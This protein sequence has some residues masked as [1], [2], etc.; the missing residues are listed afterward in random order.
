MRRV[1]LLGALAAAL[2]PA[3]LPA[4]AGASHRAQLSAT[5]TGTAAPGANGT[6]DLTITNNGPDAI[7]FDRG[8]APKALDQVSQDGQACQVDGAQWHCGPFSAPANGEVHLVLHSP[9]GLSPADGPFQMFVSTDGKTDTGPF[10]IQWANAQ[11]KPCKCRKL[12]VSASGVGSGQ[13]THPNG[14]VSIGMTITWRLTC[15]AGKG[16]CRG[17]I[18]AVPPAGSDVQIAQPAGP[19]TCTAPCGKSTTGKFRLKARSVADLDFDNRAGKSFA[20]G[21][22]ITC[23]KRTSV[24][25][26]TLAFGPRGFLDRKQS[27]LNANGIPDG[28][29]K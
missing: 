17:T 13:L 24:K 3:V 11:G 4:S 16:R 25:K 28:K 15:S 27:D 19:V 8:T 26:V 22:K 5:I 18:T 7:L 2:L 1:L 6:A 29:E 20:F 10:A 23:G 21:F 9:Q 14:P 12:S